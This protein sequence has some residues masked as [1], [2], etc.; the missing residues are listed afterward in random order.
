MTFKE[1]LKRWNNGIERGAPA[2]LARTLSIAP[3][4]VSQWINL[5][6]TPGEELLRKIAKLFKISE[7]EA[8][9]M[10]QRKKHSEPDSDLRDEVD[11]LREEVAR[12]SDLVTAALHLE[13]GSL[14]KP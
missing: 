12:L 3:N 14:H 2:R 5:G 7:T 4:T 10:F 13:K 11:A 1:H 9:G 8:A 6:L